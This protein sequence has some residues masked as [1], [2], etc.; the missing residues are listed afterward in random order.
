MIVWE[1]KWEEEDVRVGDVEAGQVVGS[2]A[3]EVQQSV[4]GRGHH[5]R[6]RLV[7]SVLWDHQP[8]VTDSTTQAC[9]LERWQNSDKKKYLN[10]IM[11][12]I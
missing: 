6:D 3:E 1:W 11:I 10:L 4:A 9:S 7:T 5:L 12:Y 8:T 2:V